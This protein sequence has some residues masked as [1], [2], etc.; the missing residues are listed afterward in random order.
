MSDININI[1]GS[2]NETNIVLESP[3]GVINVTKK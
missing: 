3:G 2:Y 1:A